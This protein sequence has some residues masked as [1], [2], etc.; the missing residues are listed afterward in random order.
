MD[1]IKL[2]CMTILLLLYSCDSKAQTQNRDV[3]IE[4]ASTD[5]R[6]LFSN[7]NKID[8]ITLPFG[9]SGISRQI[10][11]DSIL[12]AIHDESKLA[13]LHALKFDRVIKK[14]FLLLPEE[15]DVFLPF[16]TDVNEQYDR[17]KIASHFLCYGDYTVYLVAVFNAVRYAEPFI[18]KIY[19][20]SSKGDKLIDM[21]RIYLNHQG[22]MGFSNYTLFHIDEDHIISLQDY[23]FTENPF[24]LKPSRKYKM[25]SSGKFSRYYDKNGAFKD[26]EEQGMVKNHA[27]EG[28][29]I[30]SKPNGDI[31]LQKFPEFNDTYT[32]LEAEY[33]N[34][35][36]IGKWK[37]YKLLQRY[38]EE[39]GEPIFHTRKRGQLIFTEIYNNGLLE[40]REFHAANTKN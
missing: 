3:N 20:V 8:C 23:E 9:Y 37:F 39:T 12:S 4:R 17:I 2:A 19:L 40:K 31:D 26:D 36:P 21:K 18:E 33:K 14:D 10:T 35:L 30:E 11:T 6:S 16:K 29:W 1:R 7:T 38:N 27:K 13:E 22:E 34:G 5:E 28:K 32:Y 15:Y 24:K 25:L